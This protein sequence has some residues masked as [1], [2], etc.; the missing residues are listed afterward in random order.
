MDIERRFWFR[1]VPD[2]LTGATAS[3]LGE[4]EAEMAH[5]D[6]GVLRH[7][8]PRHDLSRWVAEV[9]HDQE[10]AARIYAAEED[11]EQDTPAALVEAARLAIL[12]AL[13]FRRPR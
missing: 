11:I 5:C 10:L 2:R 1:A 13:R 3:N 12:A 7:H 9:F 8:A 6:R 4:L